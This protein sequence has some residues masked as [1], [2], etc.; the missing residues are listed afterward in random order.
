MAGG[1]GAKASQ[2]QGCLLSGRLYKT[3]TPQDLDPNVL[4]KRSMKGS[5]LLHRPVNSSLLS[6]YNL[7]SCTGSARVAM[8]RSRFWAT[9]QGIMGACQ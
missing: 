5:A 7:A 4:R 6:C 3:T 1:A 9:P 8:V 2:C